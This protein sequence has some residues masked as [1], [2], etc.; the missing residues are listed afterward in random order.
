MPW[1]PECRY[2]YEPLVTTCPDCSV[3]L[4]AE[5][6]VVDAGNPDIEIKELPPVPGRAYAGMLTE[7]LEKENIPYMV[8]DTFISTALQAESGIANAVKIKVPD[9]KYDRAL[10]LFHELFPDAKF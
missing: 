5:M 9:D 2:E 6:P 4:V 1:C 3:T 7:L 8:K 10:H